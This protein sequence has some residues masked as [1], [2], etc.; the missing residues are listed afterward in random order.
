MHDTVNARKPVPMHTGDRL[1]LGCLIAFAV[2]APHSI[3]LT[4]A[5]F[6]AGLMVWLTQLV[7]RRYFA[8]R[9]MTLDLPV[10]LFV[11]WSI[12][13]AVCSYEPAVSSG[14]LR[15]VS[16]FLIYFLVGQNLRR[17]EWG[18]RLVV[19]LIASSF[20]NVG[21]VFWEKI[22][23]RGMVIESLAED[24]PLRTIGME[25]GDV[26]LQVE[27]KTINS[28]DD[29]ARVWER[30]RG[31]RLRVFFF[32]PEVYLTREITV[33]ST[34]SQ[35]LGIQSYRRW[36]EFRAAGFYGWNYFTYAEV[37]Q[38]LA[39]LLLGIWLMRE[40]RWDRRGCVILG[41]VILLGIALLLTVTRAAWVAFAFSTAAMVVVRVGRKGLLVLAVF[42]LLLA[43]AA[44]HLLERTRGIS[45]LNLREPSTS[46]RLTVW[47][48]GLELLARQPRHWIVGVG[49][50]SLKRRWREWGLFQGGRLPLGHFHSTPIQ[51]AV[52]RGLPALALFLWWFALYLRLQWRLLRSSLP[53]KD[54]MVG[55]IVLGT[56][57]GTL[58]FLLSSLVH[59]N[60]GDSEVAMIVYFQ[61]GL[62]EVFRRWSEGERG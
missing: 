12:L 56:L 10:I 8:Y 55:G 32:R 45:S 27:G 61:M 17:P 40:K 43:P 4:Q 41:G 29:L 18:K 35:A 26:L 47:R 19:A 38:L 42:L 31:Q 5:A 46:Y 3:A 59:Y 20:L 24:S 16:L 13:A 28:P 60:F 6:G 11:G 49:M 22:A 39:S 2:A 1:L 33:P 25:S 7:R 34:D 51:I 9:L 48:E 57:G 37:V 54:P 23:G 58:G 44:F 53:E 14:K 36:R 52:E 62:M 50:D 30:R 15:S 21:F